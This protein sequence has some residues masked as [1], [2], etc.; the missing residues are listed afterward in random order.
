M[1]TRAL[2]GLL[3][4]FGFDFQPL[5]PRT[6]EIG[7]LTAA[8]MDKQKQK[9]VRANY[10][11]GVLLAA[12]A[13]KFNLT[14]FLEFGT[15]RGFSSGCVAEF[16]PGISR[17]VTV[18]KD[19]PSRTRNLLKQ[20]RVSMDRMRFVTKMTKDLVVQDSGT[21][22]DL[23]LIDAQHD[24]DA[25]NIDLHFALGVAS[26]KFIMVFDDYNEKFNSVQQAILRA[27]QSGLFQDVILAMTDGW[28]IDERIVGDNKPCRERECGSGMVVASVGIPLVCG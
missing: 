12:L 5:L 26:E 13:N 21:G 24:G 15:G 9:M 18:D 4:D 17:I 11:R 22:F 23:F 2:P 3:N 7:D 27:E 14:A 1:I 20:A 6:I 28:L 10:E 16:C 8:R 19:D 25:V